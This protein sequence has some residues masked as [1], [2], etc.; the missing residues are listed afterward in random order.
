[1]KKKTILL[2]VCAVVVLGAAAFFGWRFL[3]GSHD[4]G[5]ADNEDYALGIK[6]LVLLGFFGCGSQL[7]FFRTHGGFHPS[8]RFVL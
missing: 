1:M 8:L 7:L 3:G 5:K 2:I 4:D 6:L